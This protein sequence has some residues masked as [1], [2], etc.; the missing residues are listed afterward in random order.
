M[1]EDKIKPIGIDHEGYEVITKAVLALL[2]EYGEIIGRQIMFEELGMDSGIAFSSNSGA[3]VISETHNILGD[4]SQV[5]RYP[6]FII[7]RTASTAERYKL[8]ADAFL[9]SVGKWICGE[10]AVINGKEYTLSA[11]PELTGGRKITR[12]TRTNSYPLEPNENKVQ[13]WLLP[14][15]VEYT[16][17]IKSKW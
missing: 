12:I 11:F 13:D 15:T 8:Q 17:E 2:S 7:Y 16:N 10:S 3:L 9:D 1:A 6:F 5:C 14:V 4:Y